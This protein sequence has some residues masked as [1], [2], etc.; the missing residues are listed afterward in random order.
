M[1]KVWN[2]IKRL[3]L[4]DRINTST[5][6]VCKTLLCFV[7]YLLVSALLT[8]PLLFH[9]D[10]TLFRGYGDAY[11][12]VW[13]IWINIPRPLGPHASRIA[14][15]FELSSGPTTGQPVLEMLVISLAQGVGEVAG[16][17]LFVI[18]S[19]PLTA[20]ATYL[21]LYWVL[22]QEAAA[23]FGGLIFG[24]SPATVMHAA[25]GHLGFALNAFIPLLLLALFYNR[26][27]R[28]RISGALAGAA[29]A[30]LTLTCLYWGYFGIYA[31]LYFIA[32]DYCNSEAGRTL[33]FWRNYS[34]CALVAGLIIIPFVHQWLAILLFSKKSDLIASGYV[35][36]VVELVTLSARPWE[37]FVPSIDHPLLGRFVEGFSRAH[38]HGSNIP[39]QTLYLGLIPLL[40]VAAGLAAVRKRRFAPEQDALFKFFLAG[41]LWMAFLSAPPYIPIGGIKIPTLSYFA[42]KLAPM[43]RAY[44]RFGIWVNFFVACAAATVLAHASGQMTKL[45]FRALC[46]ALFLPLAFEYWSIPP[47]FAVSVASPP[48]V[49]RW[50]ARQPGDFIVAEYPMMPYDE[51]A[52][53]TYPFWQRIHGKRLVNGA[54]RGNKAAWAYYER[55]RD[56]AGPQTVRLLKQAGV[57]YILVHPK[58]Y[59]EGEIPGP[60]KRYFP[61]LIAARTYNGGIVPVNPSLRKPY[62]VFGRDLVYAL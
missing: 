1:G 25:A 30:L 46:A 11:G 42:F 31:I 16:Y 35:R 48:P 12:D 56:L 50:L 54:P 53:Y 34:I 3:K 55:V 44:C 49:Y 61:P 7:A 21:F 39:E 45:R 9:M 6:S 62:K 33:S 13:S 29:Y 51:A 37:Y 59:E 22:R 28:S 43:F 2:C 15:P 32:W 17:N 23:F 57:R 38:L 8:W 20:L 60:I 40:T 10:S 26:N 18:L 47:N 14:A 58:M 24:F 36:G 41:A 27:Q 19:L 52:F 5:S 4:R